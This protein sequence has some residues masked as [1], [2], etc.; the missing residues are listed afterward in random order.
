MCVS[1][2]FLNSTNKP[3]VAAIK[4]YNYKKVKEELKTKASTNALANPAN[5]I[6]EKFDELNEKLH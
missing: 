1:T 5:G 2:D 4:K 6:D 3:H